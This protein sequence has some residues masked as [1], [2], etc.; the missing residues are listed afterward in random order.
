MLAFMSSTWTKCVLELL[1]TV[2]G[3]GALKVEATHLRRLP[4]PLMEDGTWSELGELGRALARQVDHREDCVLRQIDAA[5]LC[6]FGSGRAT[7]LVRAIRGIAAEA[8]E[9]RRQ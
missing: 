4:V 7:A 8:L 5:V 3:G 6:G 2:L 1:G 9:G